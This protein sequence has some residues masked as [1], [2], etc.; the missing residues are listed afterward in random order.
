MEGLITPAIIPYKRD[1]RHLE[2]LERAR[3]DLLVVFPEWY[4]HLVSR[5]DLFREVYRIT[6]PRVSAAHDTLVVYRTPWTRGSI[7]ARET[8]RAA[9]WSTRPMPHNDSTV[10]GSEYVPR[11]NAGSRRMA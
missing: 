8:P 7:E 2:Y 6:V 11:L 5:T 4:P 10:L 1:R 3:P 9:Q